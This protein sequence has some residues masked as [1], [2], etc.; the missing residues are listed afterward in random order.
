VHPDYPDG[1]ELTSEIEQLNTNDSIKISGP[2]AK[3]WYDGNGE[4][5]R[6]FLNFIDLNRTLNGFASKKFDTA[7]AMAAGSGITPIFQYLQHLVNNKDDHTKLYFLYA[8]KTQVETSVNDLL[9]RHTV[10]KGTR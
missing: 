4:F 7:V 6:R 2:V 9:V 10:E 5:R 8:N 1:G 3:F